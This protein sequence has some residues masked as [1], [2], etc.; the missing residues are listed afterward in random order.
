MRQQRVCM[1]SPYEEKRVIQYSASIVY[2]LFFPLTHSTSYWGVICQMGGGERGE[3]G[4]HFL[5]LH[6]QTLIRQCAG[7]PCHLFSA[8]S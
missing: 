5:N 7:E 6:W 8:K 1:H 3:G 2:I 4:T